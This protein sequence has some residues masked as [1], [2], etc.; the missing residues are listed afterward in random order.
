MKGVFLRFYTTEL[1]KHDGMPVYDWLLDQAKKMGI[2]GGSEF[3]AIAG[4]GRRGLRKEH[5]F[6]QAD[7]PVEVEFLISDDDAARFLQVLEATERL[8]IFYV[9]IAADFGFVGNS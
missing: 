9:K 7:L 2:K 4:Y 6:E 8:S 3:R 5:F 1:R